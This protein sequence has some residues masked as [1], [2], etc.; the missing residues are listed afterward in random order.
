[1]KND[2]R[3]KAHEVLRD[4]I[5]RQFKAARQRLKTAHQVMDNDPE[6]SQVITL[7]FSRSL[8]NCLDLNL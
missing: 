4:Q 6:V 5:V 1:M 3:F 8:M 2:S 7:Q